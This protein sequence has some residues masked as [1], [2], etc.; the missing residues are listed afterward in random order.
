MSCEAETYR[1]RQRLVVRG[2][3]LSCEAETCRARRR[4][5]VRG[6]DLSREGSSSW[7]LVEDAA[8]RSR[9]GRL[10]SDGL[11]EDLLSFWVL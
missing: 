1:V 3:D 5:V 11:D 2:G 4:L 8:V 9:T 10:A 6:G 7:K